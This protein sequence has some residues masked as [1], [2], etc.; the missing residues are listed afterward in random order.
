MVAKQRLRDKMREDLELRGMSAST[1]TYL[2]CARRLAEHCGRSP[3]ALGAPE[4]R[5]FLPYLLHERRVAPSSFNVYAS[6][7]KLRARGR[8]RVSR[9]RGRRDKRSR[10]GNRRRGRR[11]HRRGRSCRGRGIRRLVVTLGVLVQRT[12]M[13]KDEDEP[14]QEHGDAEDDHRADQQPQDWTAA[15][16]TLGDGVRATVDGGAGRALPGVHALAVRADRSG[17]GLGLLAASMVTAA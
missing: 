5:A 1:I 17:A 13:E 7:I 16:R 15:P 8:Q 10:S 11:R 3:G 2:D 9:S 14:G 12:R 4:I 6:A